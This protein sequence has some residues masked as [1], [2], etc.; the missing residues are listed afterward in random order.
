MLIVGGVVF[1]IVCALVGLVIMAISLLYTGPRNNKQTT[2][3]DE[4]TMKFVV[5]GT[6]LDRVLLNVDDYHYE[7]ETHKIIKDGFHYDL[8]KGQ[9]VSDEKPVEKKPEPPQEEPSA[10]SDLTLREGEK[11]PKPKPILIDKLNP[12]ERLVREFAKKFRVRFGLKRGNT[13]PWWQREF[14]VWWVSIFYPLKH[15]Y[16]FTINK[17]RMK[18]QDQVNEDTPLSQKLEHEP[19]AVVD[20]L[21]WQFQI[22]FFIEEVDFKDGTRVNFIVMALFQVVDPY[23]AVFIHGGEKYF[24][25]LESAVGAA[26]TD[27]CRNKDYRE[28]IV[29]DGADFRDNFNRINLGETGIEKAVGIRAIYGQIEDWNLSSKDQRMQDAVE[30]KEIAKRKGEA[31]VETANAQKQA[32]IL[33]A[34]AE[35]EADVLKGEGEA[36]RIRSRAEAQAF[37]L[38]QSSKA[39]IAEGVTASAAARVISEQLRTENIAG[40]DSKIITYVEGGGNT[41]PALLINKEEERQARQSQAV[42]A[43]AEPP[44]TQQPPTEPRTPAQ[45]QG[46][47][48]QQFN[49]PRWNEGKRRRRR[50]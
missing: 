46:E 18:S 19:K 3:V 36:S 26:V 15:I 28:F 31:L 6:S 37:R 5:K 17:S 2:L 8:E 33:A 16:L 41:P 9:E 12:V 45:P 22:P 47:P 44:P 50:R 24:N 42:A 25:L 40:P 49:Q 14:G 32:A 23:I 27:Y 1:L 38:G 35:K 10:T 13:G 39:L 29:K 4:G 30:E 43:V 7:P 34:Q 20:N 11:E 48:R 21:R